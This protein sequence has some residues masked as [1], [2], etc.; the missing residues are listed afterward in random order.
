MK[1]YPRDVLHAWWKEWKIQGLPRLLPFHGKAEAAAGRNLVPGDVC[2]LLYQ[3]KVSRY[4]RLCIVKRVMESE[5]GLVRTVV[6]GLRNRRSRD[7][8]AGHSEPVEMEVGVQRLCLI[9]LREEQTKGEVGM[10][11]KVIR[12]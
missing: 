8:R 12:D 2:Q 7:V 9:L 1:A 6:V 11:D 10:T 5:D 4:Y 3:T